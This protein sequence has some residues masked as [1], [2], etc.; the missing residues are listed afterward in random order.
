MD[1]IS[2]VVSTS[3]P[4]NLNAFIFCV[5]SSI[6][7]NGTTY[8]TTTLNGFLN[9]VKA[10]YTSSDKLTI[11]YKKATPTAISGTPTVVKI[12]SGRQL[13][14][15]TANS[16]MQITYNR[17]INKADDEKYTKVQAD[18]KFAEIS[19]VYSKMDSEKRFAN[20]I[21]ETNSA[22]LVNNPN[23]LLN[24]PFVS[25]SVLGETKE[26]GTGDKSPDNSYTLTSAQP[27]QVVSC[28]K[29]IMINN[30]LTRSVNGLTF[31]VNICLLYTSR[32]V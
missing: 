6:V 2:P 12:G 19:K 28:G 5:G 10:L 31:T 7:Y 25:C 11:V 9:W 30:A 20:A 27:T 1:T 22:S 29:N 16:K 23:V 17:D 24:N 3:A 26:V 15:N 13:I 18:A 8:D 32:C 14:T 4:S 21:V